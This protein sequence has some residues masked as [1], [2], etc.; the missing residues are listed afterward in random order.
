MLL[1]RVELTELNDITVGDITGVTSVNKGAH[2]GLVVYNINQCTGTGVYVWEKNQWTPIGASPAEP[3][4]KE[5]WAKSNIYWDDSAQS[6]TFSETDASK[7]S[8][9][10]VY[11]KY[12]SLVGISPG[13]TSTLS[14]Y[15]ASAV[16][17]F[18]PEIINGAYTGNWLKK[19][20]A[21]AKTAG[22]FTG[23][24][25]ADI[26]YDEKIILQQDLLTEFGN[27]DRG[28]QDYNVLYRYTAD[29]VGAPIPAGR[30]YKGDIC[31]FLSTVGKAKSKLTRNWAMP[32]GVMFNYKWD[33]TIN[34]RETISAASVNEN[35]TTSLNAS[36]RKFTDLKGNPAE[37]INLPS[38][39]SRSY[40]GAT[41][42]GGGGRT[43]ESAYYRSASQYNDG[44]DGRIL[45]LSLNWSGS[46]FQFNSTYQYYRDGAMSVRCVRTDHPALKK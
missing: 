32:S 31:R 20:P 10:G 41:L 18:I 30:E 45:Y 25:Y 11:F 12:G 44:S 37:E 9:Q 23:S 22:I 24:T 39:G 21:D 26:P 3:C 1:P 4:V 40:S 19:S 27:S 7:E 28:H 46:V 13:P 43:G 42:P 33:E 6:L 17:V 35:G 5:Y 14:T 29:A 38:S 16:R 15:S 8:L 36:L 34:Q 2:T